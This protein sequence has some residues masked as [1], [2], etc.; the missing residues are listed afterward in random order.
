MIT[1]I[2]LQDFKAFWPTF[3]EIIQAQQTYAFDPNMSFKE[4][5]QL[6]CQ[7]PL[8]A[9]VYKV[10]GEVLGTYYLK[11]NAMGPSSHICNCGYMVSTA[12]RGQGIAQKLCKHSQQIAKEIG[13]E[14]MQFNSVV[15][16]NE[17][18]IRLWQRLG[19]SIIGTIPKAYKHP[20]LGY[21]DSHI[22]HKLLV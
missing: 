13:F 1:A 3:E 17:G 6:W 4:A 14:A 11:A 5:Y 21:V 9:F 22:M 10:D 2:T 15:S 7:S 12:A 18:A 20:E 16:T 19:Y 8:K